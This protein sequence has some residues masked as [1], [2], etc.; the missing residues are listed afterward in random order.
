MPVIQATTINGSIIERAK[1]EVKTLGDLREGH[2]IQVSL[3]VT[4]KNVIEYMS[5]G[6]HPRNECVLEKDKSGY[7]I[8]LTVKVMEFR[9]MLDT[10]SDLQSMVNVVPVNRVVEGILTF[11]LGR[12][13]CDPRFLSLITK[14]PM[15]KEA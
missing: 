7:S 4:D 11:L 13:L 5:K 10:P 15:E 14:R 8:I 12:D 1:W 9:H 2:N 3:P 6:V